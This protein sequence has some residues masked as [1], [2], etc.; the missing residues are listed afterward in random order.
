MP[1]GYLGT[2]P[3]QIKKNSGVFSVDDINELEAKGHF[4]GSYELIVTRSADNS[5]QTLEFDNCFS[6][7]YGMYLIHW[8][9]F[10]PANDEN[11]IYFRFKNAS[12]EVTSGYQYAN[13]RNNA[14]GGSGEEKSTS[15]A[16][17]KVHGGGG[18]GTSE[19]QNGHIFV[20]APAGSDR[21]MASYSSTFIDQ[22]ALYNHEMGGGNSGTAEAT[23]GFMFRSI[24]SGGTLGNIN[25]LDVSVYGVKSL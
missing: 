24:A 20:Y 6:T 4:G 5:A 1:Y 17:I 13:F 14:S 10:V 25:S 22:N 23:P 8:K 12:G 7:K 16:F 15:A 11:A 2:A 18:S 21:T 3:N 19:A 9:D